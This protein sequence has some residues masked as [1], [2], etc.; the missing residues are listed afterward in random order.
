MG[1]PQFV[2]GVLPIKAIPVC[3]S[4]QQCPRWHPLMTMLWVGSPKTSLST[5]Q[6]WV[7]VAPLKLTP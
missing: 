5:P 4:E 1:L 2:A 3:D 6:R 7:D